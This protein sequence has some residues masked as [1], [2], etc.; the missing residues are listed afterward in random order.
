MKLFPRSFFFLTS[1]VC[2]GILLT[3]AARAGDDWRPIDPAQLA[4][5][6]STV[7]K[8]ADAEALFWEVRV[9]DSQE[10]EL[11]LKHYVR[12]KI[13]TERGKESQSKVDIA[14]LGSTQIR[15]IAARVIKA[16]GSIVELK[17]DDVFERTI[18]KISGAKVKAKSF[19]LPGVE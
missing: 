15:D 17:K 9:D 12:I 2:F 4:M 11:S 13:F 16:D 7:E 5:N 1:V 6:A 18:V 14:Y 3:P 10:T 8:D 19:T